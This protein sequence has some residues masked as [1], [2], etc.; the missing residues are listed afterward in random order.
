[1]LMEKAVGDMN[2][3]QVLVYLDD[4]IVFGK[5]LEEHKEQLFKVLDR[6]EECGL[7]VSNDKFQFVQPQVKFLGSPCTTDT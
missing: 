1:M 2:L 5:T 3:I 4:L 7:K 6:L